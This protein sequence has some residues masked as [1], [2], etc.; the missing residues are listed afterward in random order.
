MSETECAAAG[1][2]VV[3]AAPRTGSNWLCSLLDSHPEV[4][5]HPEIFNPERII[6]SVSLRRGELDLGTVEQR[7]RRPRAVIERVWQETL[8]R[9]W[10]GFKLN[11]GQ[12]RP[13]FDAMLGEPAVRKI[14]IRR[15]NRIK[16]FASEK[17]ALETGLWESYPWSKANSKMPRIRVSV[18]ELRAHIA[19]NDR[20]YRWLETAI[21]ESGGPCLEVTY[22]ELA[23]ASE[24]AR[25][26]A[27][28]T[29]S[30]PSEGLSGMTTKQ[31]SKDLRRLIANFDEL[32]AELAGTE[33]AAELHDLGL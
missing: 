21:E 3:F 17:L 18:E 28:L 33:L 11:R 30:E 25:L 10:V 31:G 22:E 8:G 29:L 6:Y 14:L 24:R 5:C 7:D 4:L 12:S 16:T 15:R 27:F 32:A 13:A 20:Y 23:T 1:R 26:L 9:R 19:V 2:F